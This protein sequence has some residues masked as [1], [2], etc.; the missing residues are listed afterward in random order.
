MVKGLGRNILFV[1]P[2]DQNVYQLAHL[3]SIF[4]FNVDLK[5]FLVEIDHHACEPL[6]SNRLVISLVVTFTALSSARP[7][8]LLTM[9][10]EGIA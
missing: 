9:S 2:V 8:T 1:S 4:R 6:K 5:F 10:N 3:H 7:S